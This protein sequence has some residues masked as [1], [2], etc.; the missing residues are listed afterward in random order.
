[1]PFNGN[2]GMH[3]ASWRSSFGADIYLRNGSHGC[4][5]LPPKKAEAVYQYV[6]KGRASHRL[7]RADLCAKARDFRG[8]RDRD[9][10][11]E[12]AFT[13]L[14]QEQQIQLLIEAGL[15]NPDG[16]P[17][18]LPQETPSQVPQENPAENVPPNTAGYSSRKD[19][20]SRR[21]RCHRKYR[22]KILQKMCLKYRRVFHK[23][24]CQSSHRIPQKC[25]TGNFSIFLVK[26]LVNITKILQKCKIL[27]NYFASTI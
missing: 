26:C 16:T 19:L 22:R 24:D 13:E 27:L 2:V 5:N 3:D 10:P 12:A 7:R 20:R 17:A 8:A 11:E 18:Q 14:T 9:N 6:E 25:K 21:R 1:M 23:K 15:L 4:V